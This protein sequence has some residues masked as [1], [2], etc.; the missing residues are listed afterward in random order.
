MAQIDWTEEELGPRYRPGDIVKA[1]IS[2]CEERTS[3]KGDPMFSVTLEDEN[4]KFVCY[5]ILMLGGPGR[6]IGQAKLSALGFT[7]DHGEI[8]PAQ[9]IGRQV[10]VRLTE[11]EW[12]G[13]KRLKVDLVRDD[14]EEYARWHCGYWPVRDDIEPPPKPNPRYEP[15]PW[16]G[17]EKTPF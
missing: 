12:D 16:S 15:A 7:K 8:I 5:D 6:G 10:Y 14:G 9:L 13:K 17:D 2:K 1:T 3:K 4:K 11:D